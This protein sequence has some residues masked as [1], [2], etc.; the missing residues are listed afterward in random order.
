VVI[1]HP[2]NGLRQID[3]RVIISRR[4]SN[5][6]SAAVE[7]LEMLFRSENILVLK[8]NVVDIGKE[9][10]CNCWVRNEKKGAN[11]SAM[12]LKNVPLVNK[13]GWTTDLIN[14]LSSMSKLT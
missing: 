5:V 3:M 1:Q 11:L 14:G 2:K 7:T 6:I 9:S 13:T 8:G 12:E 4:G 10:L